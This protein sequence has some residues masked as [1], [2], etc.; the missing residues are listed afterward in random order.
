MGSTSD[1]GAKL[2]VTG[3]SGSFIT[4]ITNNT[5]GG[6]F[7]NMIGD[8]GNPVFTFN[9]GGTGGE[10]F[11]DMYS[12]N[13]LKN[14]F[15]ANGVSYF[16]GGNLGLGTSNPG[17]TPQL[18]AQADSK[19]LEINGNASDAV[20][21]L[22]HNIER[23]GD[24]WSDRNAA[25]LFI[26]SRYDSGNVIGG[27]IRFRT[28]TSETIGSAINA[29]TIKQDG[30]VGIG[31]SPSAKF[32]VIGDGSGTVKMGATGFG[33]NWVGISLSGTLNTGNYNLLSS[34]TNSNFYL[35]RPT[36]GDMLFRHDNT[37]QMIIK[38]GG[39]V[40]IGSTSDNGAK[41]QVTG[42]IRT[43]GGSV[44]AG[45]DYGFT[46]E[47][48]G[49][50][51]RYGLKFGAAGSVGGSNLLMLTNRSL[52]SATGGGEVAIGA[53][54][55]TTGVTETEVMRIKAITQSEVSIDGILSLTVQDTPAD[56]SNNKSS[57]WLDSNW[58]LK[59]KIT[60]SSGDTVTKTIVEYA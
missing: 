26:D 50:N 36:N 2:Q 32:E 40:L 11:L 57:I 60:N 31:I 18:D 1:N 23:G 58:D 30:N 37:D 48:E 35:N 42:I 34:A 39:N 53:N 3:S 13:V 45:Q 7:L 25:N 33:G 49:N 44:Q 24:I 5:A 38:S 46:L 59:I 47:D 43:T 52:S 29:M 21:S 20:L 56:P 10:A 4:T 51:N 28:R 16:N 22:R 14:Q 41:L 6:D 55:S 9:S 54:A 27:D 12:D 17:L 15:N 8:A 19:T